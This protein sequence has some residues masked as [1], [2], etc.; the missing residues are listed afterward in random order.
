MFLTHRVEEVVATS[1]DARRAIGEFILRERNHLS[2]YTIADIAQATYSSKASV[3][4]FAKTLG[5]DGWRDF[6]RDFMAEVRYE[7][8]HATAVDPNYP[9]KAGDAD[10]HVVNAVADAQFDAVAD[11]IR[12]LNRGILARA[13]RQ[14][15]HARKV[16]VFGV[17]PNSY[18]GGLFCRKML[19]CGVSAQVVDA[20]EHGIVARSL[21]PDDCAL[22]I[23]YSGNNAS[24]NPMACVPELIKNKVRTIAI[25]GEGDNYLRQ[26]TPCT[27][28]ISSRESLYSK[29]ATFGTEASIL[30][31]LNALFACYFARNYE[32]NIERKISSS[33][34]L[35]QS[36]ES[37][38]SEK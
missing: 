18:L 5:Y 27:L 15:E 30:F 20:D 21:G 26:Q 17:S 2:D 33:M 29:I 14:L 31:L 6:I 34:A 4:R 22:I 8:G 36:R 3:T 13:V 25:T 11:T 23:S 1:A 38:S 7:S 32:D 28:T 37:L 24:V 12:L 35:E 16:W 10:E 19:S 9:F